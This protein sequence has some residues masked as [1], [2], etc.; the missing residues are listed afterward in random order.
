MAPGSGSN[1]IVGDVYDAAVAPDGLQRLAAIVTRVA[2]GGSADLCVLRGNELGEAAT[3]NLPV[4]A[5]ENY[6]AYYQ[7]L[8]PYVPIAV[9]HG[10]S[11]PT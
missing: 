2:D 7:R 6:A 10:I 8:N 5:L 4:E 3:C 11:A 9:A 1:A